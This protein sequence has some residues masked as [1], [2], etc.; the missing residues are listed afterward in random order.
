MQKSLGLGLGFDKVLY[1]SLVIN[2]HN[3]YISS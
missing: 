2:W 1:A 3:E